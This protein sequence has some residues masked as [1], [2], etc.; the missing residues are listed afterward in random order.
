ML[1]GGMAVE[2]IS[3][4]IERNVLGQ[5]HR[6]IALRHRNDTAVVAV[7]DR[8][9]A[10]PI[11]L[12]RNTPVAQTKIDLALRYRLIAAQLGLEPARNLLFGLRDGHPIEKARVDEQPVAVVGGVGDHERRR[13]LALRAHHRR[14]AEAVF[15]GELKVALIMRRASE[16][17]AGAVVHQ[18]EVRHIDRQRPVAIERMDRAHPGVES[19]LLGFVD[20]FLR[21]AVA[22]A[23]SDERRECG[24]L[25]RRRDRERMIG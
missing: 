2:R 11:A 16:D 17:R 24:V 14:V 13:V 15:V 21:G 6:Q 3:R 4:A 23:L 20:Q 25:A 19:E 10:A 12:T 22:F 7:N 1:P 8:N 9:R 5:R 18:H